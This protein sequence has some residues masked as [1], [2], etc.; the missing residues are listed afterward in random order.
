MGERWRLVKSWFQKKLF[1]YMLTDM[2]LAEAWAVDNRV[3][4]VLGALPIT[5]SSAISSAGSG[6]SKSE[7]VRVGCDTTD[8][9]ELERPVEKEDD[10]DE[11]D[12][13]CVVGVMDD[14]DSETRT[15]GAGCGG[16]SVLVVIA[17]GEIGKVLS[18]FT[19]DTT[20]PLGLKN[21]V[22]KERSGTSGIAID[23]I[24]GDGCS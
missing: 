14:V 19:D 7:G 6:T 10:E 16:R 13:D 8:R 4:I 23:I 12:I 5:D 1:Q 18:L 22:S 21:D 24:D 3:E 15:T 20:E 2:T 9:D 11:D 17:E